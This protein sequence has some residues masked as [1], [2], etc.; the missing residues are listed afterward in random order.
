[1]KD[2]AFEK[3][4]FFYAFMQ[5]QFNTTLKAIHPDCGGEFLSMEF[6][7]FMDNKG[8]EYQLTTPYTLQ[9]MGL[10]NEQITPLL[11][12]QVSGDNPLTLFFLLLLVP[13]PLSVPF[14]PCVPSAPTPP[15]SL[16]LPVPLHHISTPSH[17]ILSHAAPSS[18]VCSCGPGSYYIVST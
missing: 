16:L 15:F 2:Q 10:Q 4:K 5:T 1:M 18:I 3:F 14:L 11:V 7:R 12:L 9:Q 6:T 8:I 13:F 17:S